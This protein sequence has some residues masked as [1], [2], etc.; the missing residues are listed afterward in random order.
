V[1]RLSLA[2]ALA[3]ALGPWR[4]AAAAPRAVPPAAAKVSPT[5]VPSARPRLVVA[6]VYDQ[7]GSET[8][9]RHLRWLDAGGALQRAV[10][11][12]V[13]LE[14]SAYP[15][16]ATLTAP[17]H[18]AIHTGTP[19]S[20]NGIDN[21]SVWE[22]ATGQAGSMVSDRAQPVFGRERDGV[23]VSPGRLQ[24]PTV[25]A[26]L[27]A[28]T[29]GAARVVSLSLKDRS[30]VLSVGSA[31]DDVLWFDTK[32]GGFTSSTAW[33]KELPAW[34]VRHQAAHPLRALLVPWRP[35]HPQQ[36]AERLGPDAAA[37]EGDLLGLGTTFPHGWEGV[38]DPLGALSCTPQMS[39]YLVGVARAAVAARA[40]GADE[41][42]DLLAL[43][44]SGTDCAGHVFGPDSWEYVDH[45]VRVDRALGKWLG[46]L[47]RQFPLSVVITSDHGVA[48]LPER[49]T[50]ASSARLVPA[51][52]QRNVEAELQRQLGAGPWIAGIVSPFVY[53]TA[54]AQA[55]SDPGRVRA[56][57][58]AALRRQPGIRDAFPAEQVRRWQHDSDALRRSLALGIAASNP[59]DF[60]L[61][62]QP[63]V[64]LDLSDTEG[65]GTN[66]GSPYAYDREI[67]VLAWGVGVPRQRSAQPVDQLRVA[68]TLAKLLGVTPP[69]AAAQPPLF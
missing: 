32:V 5:P 61:L 2:L 67:P 11:Q 45:L 29:A 41:T 27:K 17:G 22:Q 48:A 66:H 54:R 8:L 63:H 47:A 1:K 23:G 21:N 9:L 44:I 46:E 10:G 40:L 25:A 37:G 62:P 50:P 7:L 52:L 39:E 33:G 51:Q 19:P 68:A 55:H 14:R 57:A 16:A 60:V 30:A 4:P 42:P 13:Y 15:H 56:V 65:K 64:P 20:I 34:L 35:L 59:C 31:A 43:S 26:Q 69:P 28:Q 36:Y 58:L 38:R 6:L 53:L 12:G 49:Q 18:A 3:L 24:S